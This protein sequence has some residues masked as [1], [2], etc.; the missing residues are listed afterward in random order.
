[1]TPHPATHFVTTNGI[2][3]R[4]LEWRSDASTSDR[5]TVVLLHG[6]TSCAE[7]WS[8]LAPL[9][10]EERRVLAPD[11]RGHG[12]SDKPGN[13][14]D[15]Q[16]LCQDMVG[17]LDAL[18]VE[19]AAVV[20]HSWGAGV[21]ATLAGERPA[22][23]THLTLLE[24]GFFRPDRQGEPTPERLETMLAPVE[25]YASR[26]TYLAAVRSS[27]AGHWSPDIEAI[28]LASICHNGDGSVREKLSR[29]HQKLILRAMWETRTDGRYS[30]VRCPAQII[31]AESGRPE[32]AERMARKRSAVAEAARLLPGCWVHWVA[33]AVHDVQ[34]HRPQ[35]V[36]ELLRAF[37]DRA[38]AH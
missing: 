36:A 2:R 23:V 1:M 7:T 19:R 24:G 9:L 15:Y 10:A 4:C 30:R 6:L 14:Y 37:L 38:P 17:L 20:G 31:A 22:R 8:L 12:D 28:A 32:A 18:G 33:D 26:E 16:T 3:M 29:E 27:L 35:G 11:L 21:A 5:Q 34:L 25:I 13:G